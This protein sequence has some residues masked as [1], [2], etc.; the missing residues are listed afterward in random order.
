M[1]KITKIILGMVIIVAVLAVGYIF[2]ISLQR[3]DKNTIEIG[4]ISPLTGSAA[5]YGEPALFS[6]LLAQ[7]EINSLGGVKGKMLKFIVEDGK[8]EAKTATDAAKK[9]IDFNKVSIILG[10]HCSTETLAIAPLAQKAKVIVMA[11]IT[12]SPDVTYAGD[13]IFRNFPSSDYYTTFSAQIAYEK[14]YRKV[15]ALYELKDFPQGQYK[16]FKKEFERLGGQIVYAE[17]FIPDSVDFRAEIAKISLVGADAIFF[18]PQGPPQAVAFLRQAAELKLLKR[19]PIIGGVQLISKKVNEDTGGLLNNRNI[20]TTDAY[21]SPTNPRTTLFIESYKQKY[22]DLPPTNL[23]YLTSSY[24]AVYLVK[25]AI[26]ACESERD[27]EC[28]KNYLYSIKDWV[29]ASGSL[30]IDENGDALTSVALHYFD[31]DG[32]EH[33]E[34][35]K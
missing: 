19:Y 4:F 24:D 35:I 14:G 8:C 13:Y 10:G 6:A 21:V 26:E 32:Q 29:G 15:A 30:T 25:E 16:S 34:Q 23:F 22:G 31:H 1:N 3:Q 18:A 2:Y 11:S 33:W 17:G 5:T 7:E 20:F 12:S 9:L 28:I 27:V